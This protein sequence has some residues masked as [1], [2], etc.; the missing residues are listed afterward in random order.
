LNTNSNFVGG[1][2]KRA[3]YYLKKGDLQKGIEGYERVLK[4]NNINNQV[5]LT[6]A[7]LYYNAQNY[8]KAEEAFKTVI[9]Q[10]PEYGLTYYSL[11]LLYAELDKT[12]EAIK[13]LNTAINKMSKNIRVYYNL[14]LLY[15]KNQDHKNA[16]NILVKGLKIDGTNRKFFICACL[17]LL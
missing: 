13:L 16:E 3:N 11:A 10:E 2:T 7:N 14:S 8:S 17:S 1:Y 4:I 15:D 9:K 12:D 5:R 6:L